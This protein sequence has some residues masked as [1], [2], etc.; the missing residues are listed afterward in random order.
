[1]PLLLS[2]LVVKPV[3]YTMALLNVVL[4]GVCGFLLLFPSG[5]SRMARSVFP[6][7]YFSADLSKPFAPASAIPEKPGLAGAALQDPNGSS[8]PSLVTPLTASRVVPAASASG[9]LAPSFNRERIPSSFSSTPNDDASADTVTREFPP[10]QSTEQGFSSQTVDRP[11][12]FDAVSANNASP[13]VSVPVAFTTSA[14][15]A[16]ASQAAALGRLQG[17]FVNNLGGQTQNPNNP[18]YLQ[19]WQAAQALSDSNFAQQFGW[20]AFVAAQLA[21]V[22]GGAN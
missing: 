13:A 7:F 9:G 20:Q 1:M 21:Q 19:S 14:D 6:Q 8:E 11:V 2:Q 22:H 15:G 12:S 10:R 4:L 17:E 3:L 18:A 5:D 16:T